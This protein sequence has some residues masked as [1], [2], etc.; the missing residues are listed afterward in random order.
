MNIPDWAIALGGLYLLEGQQRAQQ[1]VQSADTI[2]VTPAELDRVQR[3]YDRRI[4]Q[5]WNKR[6]RELRE[7]IERPYYQEKRS[8]REIFEDSE[9]MLE[10][11]AKRMYTNR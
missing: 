5:E 9:H 6:E 2:T 7:E 1:Q 4:Q 8:P 3:E 11:Q 10:E